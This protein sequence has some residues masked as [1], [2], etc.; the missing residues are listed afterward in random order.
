MWVSIN[1]SPH[2]GELVFRID[3]SMLLNL[4]VQ[5]SRSDYAGIAESNILTFFSYPRAV[6]TAQPLLH[7]FPVLALQRAVKA[8]LLADA[9]ESGTNHAAHRI[10]CACDADNP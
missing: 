2:V 8:Q 7:R 1:I 3:A 6:A 10:K 4:H 9:T 5:S